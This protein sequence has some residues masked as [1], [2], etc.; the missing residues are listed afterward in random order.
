MTPPKNANGVLVPAVDRAAQILQTVAGSAAALGVSEL[1]RQLGLNKSTVHDILI[2]L[3]HHHLLERD[4]ATKTYR[5]GYALAELGQRVSEHMDLRAA[6]RPRLVALAH[7]VEETVFLGTFHDGHVTIVDKEEAPH[8]VKITSP[9]GRRLYY[10]AGAFGKIFLAAI[11]EAEAR[12]LMREKPL[13]A[14]TAKSTTKITAYRAT[15][16]QVRKQGY[17]LD[18]EEYLAGVRAAAAPI[19]DMQGRVVAALCVVG[20]S[21]RLPH[22]KLARMAKQ[23]RDAAEQISRQLG[24]VEYPTWNGVE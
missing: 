18:D 24:A 4:D 23:T 8:D 9:L 14:Y 22:E 5:L 7:A 12:R 10:S 16:P 3:C 11:P 17:A 20:F 15:L 21:T 6:A 2:T 1:S 19:N 13:R